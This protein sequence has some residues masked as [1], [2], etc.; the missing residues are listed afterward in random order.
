VDRRRPKKRQKD[1]EQS[2]TRLQDKDRS[3][4][5]EAEAFAAWKLNRDQLTQFREERRQSGIRLQ[6]GQQPGKGQ[7]DAKKKKKQESSADE[8]ADDS[9][10]SGKTPQDGKKKKKKTSG[11]STDKEG[12][13]SVASSKEKTKG[14]REDSTKHKV[15]KN[16]KKGKEEGRGSKKGVG[17]REEDRE[18]EGVSEDEEAMES[19]RKIY[20]YPTLDGRMVM[21]TTKQGAGERAIAA[22]VIVRTQ[23]TAKWHT[24]MMDL[25]YDWR[26]FWTFLHRLSMDIEGEE[27]GP[28][29]DGR[30]LREL[31]GLWALPALRT[32]EKVQEM[33]TW[34]GNH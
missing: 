29:F 16:K 18:S 27:T 4:E 14:R 28:G 9:R 10:R 34:A 11:K 13:T 6:D 12:S 31:R 32:Q 3:E 2:G 8:S 7:K 23:P 22:T 25:K 20:T 26:R 17:E 5:N 15:S 30:Q 21:A 24:Y 1:R 19:E 33:A